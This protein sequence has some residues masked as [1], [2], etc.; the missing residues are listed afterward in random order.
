[1]CSNTQKTLS[2]PFPDSSNEHSLAERTFFFVPLLDFLPHFN[3]Y[4]LIIIF[5]HPKASPYLHFC[6][7]IVEKIT[8]LTLGLINLM[9]LVQMKKPLPW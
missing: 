5:Y 4:Y 8:R 9:K 1:M 7:M 2:F 6:G 3:N